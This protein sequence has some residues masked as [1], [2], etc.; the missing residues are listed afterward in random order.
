MKTGDEPMRT[1]GHLMQFYQ[2]KDQG[3]EE[4]TVKKQDETESENKQQETI[5]NDKQDETKNE[6]KQ[7]ETK[8]DQQQ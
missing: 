5:S 6:V 4:N 8:D 7:D 2:E 3:A 1:F